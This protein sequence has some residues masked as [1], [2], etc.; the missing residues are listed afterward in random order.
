M[1]HA[2]LLDGEAHE[3]WLGRSREGYCLHAG[4]RRIPVELLERGGHTHELVIEGDSYHVLIAGR[5]DEVHV[6][7]NGESHLL[8]YVDNLKRFAGDPTDDGDAVTRAP[9]PG[10]IIAVSVEVGQR[11]R[12][13]DALMVIESMKMET[14][15]NAAC[16]GAVQCLHVDVGQLIDKDALL[17]TLDRSASE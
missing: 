15:I 10:S 7:L 12:R 11:V 2:F 3:L 9:M 13:G 16:D 6:H 1:L 8:C 17:I 14:T 5:G 4:G